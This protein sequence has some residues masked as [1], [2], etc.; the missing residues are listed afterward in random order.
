MYFLFTDMP[1]FTAIALDRLLETGAS[2][3]SDKPIPTS[4]PIPKSRTLERTT[5][6]PA[7]KKK[8]SRPPLKPA[9]YTTP[10]VKQLPL[11]DSPSSF[12]PSPYIINHKRRGPRLHKSSSEASVLSKQNTSRDEKVDDKSFDTCSASSTGDLQFSFTN[13]EPVEEEHVNGV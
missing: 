2:K 13:P 10:E 4:M 7:V 6:A 8:V 1:T 3:P 11:V 12:P 9:L 5:S